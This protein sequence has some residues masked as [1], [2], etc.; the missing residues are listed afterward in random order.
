MPLLTV[1]NLTSNATNKFGRKK[2]EK[3]LLEQEKNLIYLFWMKMWMVLLKS[4]NQDSG[5][6]ID[7]VRETIK[8]EIKK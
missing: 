1:S 4:L 5:V 8:H 2:V 7:E 6:I 3:K